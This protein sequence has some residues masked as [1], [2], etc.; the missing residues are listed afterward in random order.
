MCKFKNMSA[1]SERRRYT[2]AAMK[3][4]LEEPA[5]KSS[6]P[7]QRA[8]SAKTNANA[9]TNTSASASASISPIFEAKTGKV[10][11]PSYKL[12]VRM[13]MGE[14]KNT[15]PREYNRIKPDF[16]DEEQIAHLEW[17]GLEDLSE[18]AFDTYLYAPDMEQD[19]EPPD[20]EYDSGTIGHP[21]FITLNELAADPELKF[22]PVKQLTNVSAEV[23]T[24]L[25]EKIGKKL[26]QLSK[27]YTLYIVKNILYNSSFC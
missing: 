10:K 7:S 13:T 22:K 19:D 6:S 11:I 18:E 20:D 4:A 26:K 25:R 21:A 8:M 14:L 17:Q 27:S 15:T 16:N 24:K 23:A 9:N 3:A 12:E 5:K 1:S 2:F